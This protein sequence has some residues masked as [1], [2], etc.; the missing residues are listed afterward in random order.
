MEHAPRLPA[1]GLVKS[2]SRVL[3]IFAETRRP[4]R[5]S[6]LADHLDIPQ[7]SASMLLIT[8]PILA[9]LSPWLPNLVYG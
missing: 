7:A 8:L 9:P 2:A 3:E 1:D 6:E 4:M 5:I